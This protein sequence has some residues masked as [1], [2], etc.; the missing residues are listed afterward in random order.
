[1][2]ATGLVAFKLAMPEFRRNTG[3][4]TDTT[5]VVRL[6]LNFQVFICGY[7]SH[8]SFSMRLTSQRSGLD[9]RLKTQNPRPSGS[10]IYCWE[11][12]CIK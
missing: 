5:K 3:S 10:L 2:T 4:N 9:G 6:G 1:M 7:Y 11:M 8:W 12:S